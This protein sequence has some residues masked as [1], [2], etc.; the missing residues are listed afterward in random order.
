MKVIYVD[1]EL[2]RINQIQELL[3]ESF[4]LEIA[5]N[6]WEGL[7]AAMLYHPDL[8]LFNL[9]S[10][11]MDGVEAVRLIRTEPKLKDLP[12][13]GFTV[14]THRE[15]EEMS[16]KVGCTKIIEY[17]FSE[18]LEREVLDYLPEDQPLE[19]TQKY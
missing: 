1:H 13:I 15:I 18:N 16:M 2:S 14:P 6:G 8:M 7:A 5:M 10:T 9:A 12:I 17:P 3:S 19:I 4:N 11:V